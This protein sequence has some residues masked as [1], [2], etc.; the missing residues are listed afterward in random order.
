[1]N[2]QKKLDDAAAT[3]RTL[4]IER[5]ALKSKC[6][7]QRKALAHEA[8]ETVK[9]RTQLGELEQLKHVAT[10][11]IAAVCEKSVSIPKDRP[12]LAALDEYLANQLPDELWE[13][14]NEAAKKIERE[15]KK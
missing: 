3:I 7:V 13:E 10:L 6:E 1:M 15:A 5:D 12:M 11:A 8:M 9:L 2:A 14:L 4:T